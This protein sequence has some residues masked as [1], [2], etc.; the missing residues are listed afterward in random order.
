MQRSPAKRPSGTKLS[1]ISKGALH[2]LWA[3]NHGHQIPRAMEADDS[4]EIANEYPNTMIR[5]KRLQT[6]A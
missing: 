1:K 6:K 3:L 2:E 4:A 5:V